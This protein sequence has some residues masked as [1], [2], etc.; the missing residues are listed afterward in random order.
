VGDAPSQHK[1]T[2]TMREACALLQTELLNRPRLAS[3]IRDTLM[4][5]GVK[6]RTLERAKAVL[7]FNEVMSKPENIGGSWYWKLAEGVAH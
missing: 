4:K 7:I 3:E 1:K 2:K 5:A 6:A